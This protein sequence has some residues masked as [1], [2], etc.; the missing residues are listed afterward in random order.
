MHIAPMY[1]QYVTSYLIA[2]G[3]MF[4]YRS[5]TCWDFGKII[6]E[7]PIYFIYAVFFASYRSIYSEV[8]KRLITYIL[9][10]MSYLFTH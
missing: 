3:T 1:L 2:T 4:Q 8:L 10:A 6:N 7:S 9:T 5:H